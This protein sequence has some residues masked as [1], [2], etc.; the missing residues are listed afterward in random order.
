MLERGGG[1]M[2][3]KAEQLANKYQQEYFPESELEVQGIKR[4][5]AIRRIYLAGFMAAV[6]YAAGRTS[7]QI[8][9]AGNT[10]PEFLGM[11]KLCN[12]LLKLLEEETK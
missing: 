10:D 12:Y 5:S 11:E 7:A 8:G 6:R 9:I 1:I 3:T 4:P 2:T